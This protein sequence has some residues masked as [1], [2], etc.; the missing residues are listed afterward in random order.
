MTWRESRQCDPRAQA[1]RGHQG[2]ANDQDDDKV[3][4]NTGARSERRNFAMTCHD[5]STSTER[6]ATETLGHASSC[7]HSTSHSIR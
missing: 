6:C 3:L 2:I 1:G 4:E 5:H 7:L